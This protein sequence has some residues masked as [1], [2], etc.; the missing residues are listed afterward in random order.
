MA[1][2]ENFQVILSLI[3]TSTWSIE[4]ISDL[5]CLPKCPENFVDFEV[6]FAHALTMM[7][8]L[9]PGNVMLMGRM[10][11]SWIP[12]YGKLPSVQGT[13]RRNQGNMMDTTLK[14]SV[15]KSSVH[16]FCTLVYCNFLK[17]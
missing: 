13:D 9:L 2:L 4:V 17:W 12:Q 1:V 16:F 8:I 15:Q 5:V 11:M 7:S 10:K 6:E 14:S 3:N